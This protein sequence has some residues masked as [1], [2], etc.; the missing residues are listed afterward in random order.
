MTTLASV[1]EQM[2]RI[3]GKNRRDFAESV[4]ARLTHRDAEDYDPDVKAML[5]DAWDD[6]DF[7][8]R[9]EA[10]V[11]LGILAGAMPSFHKPVT[12]ETVR[13]LLVRE[14]DDDATEFLYRM[15]S[16]A[17][18][19]VPDGWKDFVRDEIMDG[20]RPD[21]TDEDAYRDALS[22][23]FIPLLELLSLRSGA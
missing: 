10:V 22:N 1:Q 20:T 7:A 6:P 16:I 2:R 23:C 3:P 15:H 19:A 5:E 18:E 4:A 21:E 14:A 8:V 9:H 13:R 17:G 11:R 12:W